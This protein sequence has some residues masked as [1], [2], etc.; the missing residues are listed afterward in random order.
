[1]Q[2][3][4]KALGTILQLLREMR[5][6]FYGGEGTASWP[7][8][9][10]VIILFGIEYKFTKYALKRPFTICIYFLIVDKVSFSFHSF[11]PCEP[12]LTLLLKF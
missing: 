5:E 12:K 7:R 6:L 1:M 8:K 3:K 10:T 2:C 9:L 4:A 11:S